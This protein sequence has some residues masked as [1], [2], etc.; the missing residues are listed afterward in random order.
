MTP[1]ASE[2]YYKQLDSLDELERGL[3]RILK[4][5]MSNDT[6]QCFPSIKTLMVLF[7]RCRKTTKKY[8]KR[9]EE[10]GF[11]VIKQRKVKHRVSNN[12]FNETNQYTLLLE[13]F[14]T[15]GKK[16]TGKNTKTKSD[17]IILAETDLEKIVR[18][19]Q[20]NYSKEAIA[21]AL[22]CMRKNI[23]NGSIINNVKSYLEALINKSSDQLEQVNNVLADSK[24]DFS[25]TSNT[26]HQA[27]NY[28]AKNNSPRTKFHNFE[29]R[30]SKYTAEE[31]EKIIK[32]NNKRK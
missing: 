22:K 4:T 6:K 32:A 9:L 19:L 17:T 13:K 23:I 15:I 25:S 12:K 5:F 3:Y 11:I 20:V 7:K 27:N 30:T 28:N 14:Q 26:K 10:K 29:Q 24:N 21:S 2:T 1:M 16:K 8:L 18:E 31:L